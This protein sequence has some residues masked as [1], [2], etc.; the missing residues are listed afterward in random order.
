VT[1]QRCPSS[2]A[3]FT[4]RGLITLDPAPPLVYHMQEKGW[5]KISAD[6]VR[7]LHYAYKAEREAAMEA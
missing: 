1:L 4:R 2:N 6:N 5:T 3:R 7:D